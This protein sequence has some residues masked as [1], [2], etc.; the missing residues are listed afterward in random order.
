M[1]FRITDRH[2]FLFS[3]FARNSA[4][5]HHDAYEIFP[6]CIFMTCALTLHKKYQHFFVM[7]INKAGDR[8]PLSLDNFVLFSRECRF[9]RSIEYILFNFFNGIFSLNHKFCIFQKISFNVLQQIYQ[10]GFLYRK[11]NSELIP[12]RT[13]TE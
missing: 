8:L 4:C 9:N 3:N 12:F 5:T 11:L 2:S 1:E 7:I 6:I 13:V 10:Y